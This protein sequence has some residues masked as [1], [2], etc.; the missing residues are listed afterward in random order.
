MLNDAQFE[1]TGGYVLKP[2]GYRHASAKAEKAPLLTLKLQLKTL[3]GQNLGTVDDIPNAY[4]KCELHAE[5][6]QELESRSY[7]SKGGKSKGGEY[8]FRTKAVHARNPSFAGQTMTIDGAPDLVPELTWVRY[9]FSL[10]FSF[11]T[12]KTHVSM[13][14]CLG[15]RQ[16]PVA[17]YIYMRSPA[18]PVPTFPRPLLDPQIASLDSGGAGGGVTTAAHL[19][20]SPLPCPH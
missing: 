17:M 8:K 14:R 18:P 5:T 13:A 9:A 7:M 20:S 1:G 16:G 2:E 15:T 12:A 6:R 11:Y 19:T 10:P 4:V 3:A